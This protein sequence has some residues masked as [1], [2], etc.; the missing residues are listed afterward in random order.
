MSVFDQ[1]QA[2]TDSDLEA[3]LKEAQEAAEWV[4]NVFG[5]IGL[6]VAI[7]FHGVTNV[8]EWVNDTDTEVEVWKLDG[9]S[10]RKDYVR[11]APGQTLRRDHWIAWADNPEQF[12]EHH[13][14]VHIGGDLK[15]VFWQSG[16][17]LFL[18]PRLAYMGTEIPGVQGAG[19]NRRM[20]IGKDQQGRIGLAVGPL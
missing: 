19:G 7:L 13:G 3:D 17:G 10:S 1:Q 15:L 11:L 5:L 20:Y 6:G 4:A 18:G 8:K 14:E 9:G 2:A 12:Q 16:N